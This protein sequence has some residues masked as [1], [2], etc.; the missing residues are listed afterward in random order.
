MGT[1]R[2][3]SRVR[4]RNSSKMALRSALVRVA[5]GRRIGSVRASG[6]ISVR[7]GRGARVLARSRRTRVASGRDVGSMRVRASKSE[8]LVNSVARS[9]KTIDV[10]GLQV[11]STAAKGVRRLRDGKVSLDGRSSRA[12][13]GLLSNR[14]MRAASVGKVDGLVKLGGAPLN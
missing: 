10:D 1:A 2:F 14:G 12:V 11:G 4:V 7:R 8:A 13:G 9:G 3:S 5:S 6:P